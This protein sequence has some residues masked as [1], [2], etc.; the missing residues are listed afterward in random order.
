MSAQRECL[1]V[2]LDKATAISLTRNFQLNEI[3]SGTF[4]IRTIKSAP[5]TQVELNK[6]LQTSQ[7]PSIVHLI[8]S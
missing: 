8:V 1:N 5:Y 7:I 2:C 6:H 4:S 3:K